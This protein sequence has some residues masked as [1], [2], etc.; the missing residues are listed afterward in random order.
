MSFESLEQQH[1][2]TVLAIAI[3]AAATLEAAELV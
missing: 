1:W 2:G 3:A